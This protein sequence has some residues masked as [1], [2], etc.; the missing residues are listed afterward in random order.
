MQE[1]V[2]RR[3][4]DAKHFVLDPG[5]SPKRAIFVPHQHYQDD[6][7]NWDEVNLDFA[8]DG[9]NWRIDRHLLNYRADASGL[10]VF[11]KPTGR[12]IKFLFPRRPDR[13]MNRRVEWNLADGTTWRF[14]ARKTGIKTSARVVARRGPRTYRFDAEMLGGLAPPQEHASGN[15][16]HQHFIIARPHVDGADGITY[17]TSGWRLQAGEAAFDFDDTA[18]PDIAFPYIIDPTTTFNVSA[19][20]DDGS[21]F[22]SDASYPPGADSAGTASQS[23]LTRRTFSGALFSVEVVL[24]RWDTSSLPDAA[25]VDAATFRPRV[26]ATGDADGRSFTAEWY[27]A[28]TIGTEDYTSTAGT[29]AHAGTLIGEL[30]QGGD[31]DFALANV[32][33]VS[34]TGY[35]GLRLHISGGQPTGNNFIEFATFDNETLTEPR[36]I[37]DYT[38]GAPPPEKQSFFINRKR[39]VY[40]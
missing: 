13:V 18:L 12:G 7:G 36:L 31:N 2:A 3:V 4:R 10:S 23:T 21:V 29:D 22:A 28:G 38:E 33:N 39:R 27:E 11:H 9:L 26:I 8:T 17:E 24:V 19:S 16:V 20:G 1:I 34:L 14:A 40:R 35:T 6:E 15:L 25:T 37:V 30:L 32:S 5:R